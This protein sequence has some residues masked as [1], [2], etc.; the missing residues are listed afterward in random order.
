MS[1]TEVKT[2]PKKKM[3][4]WKKL[5]IVLTILCIAAAGLYAAV[6]RSP[7]LQM[8]V[9]TLRFAT[10]T[11]NNPAYI[12]YDVDLME[13]FCDYFNNDLFLTGEAHLDH[14]RKVGF[15]MSMDIAGERS[16]AQKKMAGVAD[17]KVLF[18][19]VGNMEFYAEDETAYLVAPML[20]N[21]S[22]AF[23]TGMDLFL[24]APELTHDLDGEWFSENRDNIIDFTGEI[25]MDVI[26]E[27]ISDDERGCVGYHITIPQGTGAFIWELLGMEMPD[28]DVEFTMFLTPTFRI[29]R[30]VF[31]LTE[32][33]SDTPIEGAVMMIDGVDVGTITTFLSLPDNESAIL[34]MVRNGAYRSTNIIDFGAT[35]F[36]NTTDIYG[37][38]GYMTWEKIKKGTFLDIHEFT[39]TENSKTIAAGDFR[40]DLLKGTIENDVFEDA[41]VN[42]Y[43]IDIITWERLRSDFDGFIDQVMDEVKERI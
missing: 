16:F 11:L 33:L 39:V 21:L 9:A 31:D 15:S 19:D 1:E 37:V 12:A 36:T 6:Y 20:D 10:E 24:K 25:S 8:L 13:L 34:N 27:E 18:V 22:Y 43:A 28:H 41:S 32:S 30:I 3:A 23:D 2:K 7:R 14:V 38:T 17:L 40:G 35:Y 5:L 42:L 4:W 26:E 29:R